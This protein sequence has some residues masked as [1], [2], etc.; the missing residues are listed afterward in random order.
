MAQNIGVEI[1]LFLSG[2]GRRSPPRNPICSPGN[3]AQEL[4]FETGEWT[5]A[6]PGPDLLSVV[7]LLALDDRRAPVAL[8]L[9]PMNLNNGD[10][11][12]RPIE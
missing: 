2:Q 4:A 9:C 10:K 6:P 7:P 3:A 11:A 1:S 5:P 12:D 8:S